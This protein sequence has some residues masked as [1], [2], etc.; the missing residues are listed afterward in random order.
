VKRLERLSSG[1]LV[2]NPQKPRRFDL[3]LILEK[4]L[5]VNAWQNGETGVRP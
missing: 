3:L 4:N 1:F 2:G 5:W